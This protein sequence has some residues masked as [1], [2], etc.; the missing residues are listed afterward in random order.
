MLDLP[1]RGQALK[2]LML[3]TQAGGMQAIVAGTLKQPMDNPPPG[4]QTV[5]IEGGTIA[6][7][8]AKA[9]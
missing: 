1:S 7:P 6:Q 8:Q 3:L 2:W 9:A 4:V 5:W